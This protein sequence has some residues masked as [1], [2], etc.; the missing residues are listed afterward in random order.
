MDRTDSIQAVSAET[1]TYV[2]RNSPLLMI[3]AT[4]SLMPL[5]KV[6]TSEDLKF[7]T[8]KGS[9]VGVMDDL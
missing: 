3:Y 8:E 9:S 7:E 6:E 1:R 5:T 4:G 2:C